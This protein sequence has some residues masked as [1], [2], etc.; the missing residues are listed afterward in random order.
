MGKRQGDKAAIREMRGFV[1]RQKE[2]G[3]H[4]GSQRVDCHAKALAASPLTVRQE[5]AGLSA[6]EAG[7][8]PPSACLLT[9]TCYI[10]SCPTHLGPSLHRMWR[11]DSRGLYTLP[12]PPPA[13]GDKDSHSCICMSTAWLL[14]VH[15]AVLSR[16][17][18]TVTVIQ[19][20]G[21]SHSRELDPRVNARC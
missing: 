11:E 8:L 15:G 21:H 2:G 4:H 10:L 12:S 3:N 17:L 5:P 18:C 19:E 13:Q 20:A 6:R 16:S 9:L 1:G 7:T 14:Q